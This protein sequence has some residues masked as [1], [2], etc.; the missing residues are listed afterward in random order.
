[1]FWLPALCFVGISVG[2]GLA[3]M[4]AEW[5]STA[6]QWQ[7]VSLAWLAFLCVGYEN[8]Y[9]KAGVA[10]L[11]IWCLFLASTDGMIGFYPSWGMVPETLLIVA[12]FLRTAWKVHALQSHQAR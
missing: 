4:P 2:Y 1:M 11:L 7:I 10:L 9:R 8:T 12:V 5:E 6:N 3:G